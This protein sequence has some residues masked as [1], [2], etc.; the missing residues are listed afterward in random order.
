MGVQNSFGNLA[1]IAAPVLTGVL[2]DRTGALS[3]DFLIAAALP[4]V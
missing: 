3:L 1:G 4:L 2:V